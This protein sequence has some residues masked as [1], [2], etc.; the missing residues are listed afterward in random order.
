MIKY[1]QQKEFFMK[2][3]LSKFALVALAAFVTSNAMAAVNESALCPLFKEL[4]GVFRAVRTLAFVGAG[5]MIAQWAW[6]YISGGKIDI[7]KE[8]KEKGIALLVGFVLLFTI[9]TILSV[10]INMAGDGGS[11]GCVADMW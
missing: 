6:G 7:I 8:V 4:G 9:G 5:L 3:L 1:R 11:L 10:F 2:K